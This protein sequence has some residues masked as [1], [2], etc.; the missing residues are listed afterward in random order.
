[1]CSLN[2]NFTMSTF[3]GLL[4]QIRRHVCFEGYERKVAILGNSLKLVC[5][6]LF[7]YLT[8]CNRRRSPPSAS[9]DT[10]D[11]LSM[12][13]PFLGCALLPMSMQKEPF[14]LRDERSVLCRVD[15]P[16]LASQRHNCSCLLV[17]TLLSNSS[18]ASNLIHRVYSYAY[19]HHGVSAI[20]A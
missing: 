6:G 9:P 11:R 3:T 1:M 5:S 14:T 7:H 10:S 16:V 19:R 13:R 8:A 12:S 18:L 17:F 20:L 15:E 2:A 4:T